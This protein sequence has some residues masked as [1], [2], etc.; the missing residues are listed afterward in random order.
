M[1]LRCLVKLTLRGR[2]ME[3]FYLI[4]GAFFG[5]GLDYLSYYLWDKGVVD[6]VIEAYKS[7]R[8]K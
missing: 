2:F 7:I 1:G 3:F 4:A 6:K 8:S 5:V